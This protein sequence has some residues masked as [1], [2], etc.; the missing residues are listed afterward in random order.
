M[1]TFLK[2]PFTTSLLG[3]T[4]KC[5]NLKFSS[6]E[7]FLL[8][9]SEDSTAKLWNYKTKQTIFTFPHS[10]TAEVLRVSFLKDD[11]TS[12]MTCSA[13]GQAIL[14]SS[15]ETNDFKYKEVCKL[16]HGNSQIYAC[17]PLANG[18][19]LITAAD[20][21][22]SIWDLQSHSKIYSWIFGQ[23]S[24]S[25]GA[26]QFGGPRN[27]SNLVFIF[28]AKV[29]H[30]NVIAVA[31]SDGSVA[32]IDMRLPNQINRKYIKD[33][34]DVAGVS[35]VFNVA[36][37]TQSHITSLTWASDCNTIMLALGN[38]KIVALD[39][40]T[41]IIRAVLTGHRSCC[42][43]TS[44]IPSIDDSGIYSGILSWSSDSTIQLWDITT[45]VGIVDMPLQGY[46]LD[47]FP[48]YDCAIRSTDG[49][50]ACAGGGNVSFMGHPIHVIQRFASPH[51]L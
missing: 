8:S 34:T 4:G 17:E 42:F 19:G 41:G 5:Y 23:G 33:L 29:N 11:V 45:A 51:P 28:D 25:K 50:I 6:C 32:F 35:S 24:T 9:A 37:L 22:L 49:S 2:P 27:P 14:W 38:G 20:D 16:S 13:D 12:L 43:G 21:E 36:N 15:V 48:I 1:E 10:K 40:R 31:L 26:V 46:S 30:E 3:H 39:Y 44:F 47:K 7:N 18:S